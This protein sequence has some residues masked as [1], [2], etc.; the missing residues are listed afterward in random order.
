MVP[1]DSSP[2]RNL[3]VSICREALTI[4]T[5]STTKASSCIVTK[6]GTNVKSASLSAKTT[7][8]AI[9]R[10]VV[11]AIMP[12]NRRRVLRLELLKEV[13]HLLPR[14]DENFDQVFSNILV[15]VVEE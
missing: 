12:L 9:V 14:F 4:K 10:L 1:L 15:V 13:A 2:R 5:P 8:K 7:T 11:S 3:V 6:G